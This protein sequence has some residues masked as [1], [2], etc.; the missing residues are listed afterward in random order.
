MRNAGSEI[1]EFAN[2]SHVRKASERKLKQQN[3]G[4]ALRGIER[5]LKSWFQAL[6]YSDFS[7]EKRIAYWR[8]CWPIS[9]A[10]IF[11]VHLIPSASDHETPPKTRKG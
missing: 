4:S 11:M 10:I 8:I 9:R 3:I 2:P 5:K 7:E 1:R 6:L